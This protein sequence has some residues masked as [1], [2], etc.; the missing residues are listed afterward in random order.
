MGKISQSKRLNKEDFPQEYQDLVDRMG[1]CINP[2]IKQVYS[3][4]S[5]GL[6]Y[7]DNFY[8]QEL[9]I[10]TKVS[11]TGVPVNNQFKYTLKTRPKSI[12]VLNVINTT[13]NVTVTSNPFVGFSISGETRTFNY[14]TGLSPN[15]D[16]NISLFVM[17]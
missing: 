14:I 13:N 15:I 1:E 12:Q 2:F 8:G 10:T 9:S 3:C 16:W 7:V 17:G 6:S 4:L 5:Q 11:A